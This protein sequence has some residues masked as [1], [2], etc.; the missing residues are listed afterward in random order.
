M[1]FAYR[2]PQSRRCPQL[3][4]GFCFTFGRVSF[5]PLAANFIQPFADSL[6]HSLAGRSIIS[7]VFQIVRQALHVCHL[8]LEF[9][10][11]LIAFSVAEMLH[12]PSWGIAEMQE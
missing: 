7:P 3:L 12:Q 5:G 1:V 9:M 6:F 8:A 10:R 2:K 4:L 11:V